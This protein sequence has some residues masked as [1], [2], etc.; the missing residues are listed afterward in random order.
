MLRTVNMQ[1]PAQQ[2]QQMRQQQQQQQQQ[3]EDES[4]LDRNVPYSCK[5]PLDTPDEAAA[6]GAAAAAGT[7]GG[8]TAADVDG[9][10]SHR[11]RQHGGGTVRHVLPSLSLCNTL[12]GAG[13]LRVRGRQRGERRYFCGFNE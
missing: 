13:L 10:G 6:A 5:Q 11:T 12:A 9:E 2:N 8:G 4:S 7:G 3:R 1:Q